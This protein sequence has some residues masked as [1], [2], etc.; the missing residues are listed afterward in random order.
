VAAGN[1]HVLALLADGTVLAW[2]GNAAGQLGLGDFK[3]RRTPVATPVRGAAV[4]R[5]GGDLSIAIT[6]ARTA[7]AWGE[8]SDGQLGTGGTLTTDQ[9]VPFGVLT[10]VVD[11]APTDRMLLL[12]GSDG[13]IRGAG[14]NDAGSLGDGTTTARNTFTAATGLAGML[15]ASS[16]GRTFAL[17]L[18]S[19][20]SIF[21]WGDNSGEQLGNS[22]LAAAGTSTPTLVPNVDAIP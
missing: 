15:G 9:S 8:N 21:S 5:A 2:G 7:L 17:A 3:L 20:G 12:V 1:E 4:I 19:D 14:A 13:A 11:A 10:A 16:G 18:R 6:S 22:T